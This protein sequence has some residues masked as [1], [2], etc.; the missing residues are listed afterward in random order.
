MEGLVS[1]HDLPE[2]VL[3]LA[4]DL[5][6]EPLVVVEDVVPEHL[7]EQSGVASLVVAP[8]PKL[9]VRTFASGVLL[10]ELQH[11]DIYP[12]LGWGREVV[13]MV[14]TAAPNASLIGVVYCI[15]GYLYMAHICI[16]FVG[17]LHTHPYYT[18]NPL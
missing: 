2:D 11:L 18:T 1:F 14:G 13:G 7:G 10:H 12:V 9:N 4:G 16:S 6:L 17:F 8:N 5:V 3:A 15:V